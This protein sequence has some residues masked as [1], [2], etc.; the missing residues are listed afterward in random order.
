[1]IRGLMLL[2]V[3]LLIAPTVRAH[4]LAPSLLEVV[5]REDGRVKLLFKTPVVQPRGARLEPV[6]PESCRVEESGK[7]YLSGTAAVVESLL[8]CGEASLVGA[9][10]GVSGLRESGTNAIARIDLGD[11]RIAQSVLHAGQPN[12]LVSPQ[13]SWIET[14]FA[15]QRLGFTHILQGL[16]HLLF[17]A[18]LVLLSGLGR[19]LLFTITAFTL[20]HSVTL[21]LAALGWLRLPAAPIEIAIA[22]SI[23]WLALA[24]VE[25]ADDDRPM[26]RHPGWMALGFGLLHGLGFAGAL[27]ET[28]LPQGDIPLALASFNIGIELGQLLF[29]SLLIA[30][31]GLFRRFVRRW[32]RWANLAAAYAVGGLAAFWLIERIANSL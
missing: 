13:P 23:L 4:P 24:L 3:L 11:G 5:V 30:L 21:S 22:L 2:A 8:D 19:R 7:V 29:V 31:A 6:Y 15:Y 26:W 20:G 12:L 28:G 14:A 9:R 27:L 17:V 16:D 10:F 18:G 25:S 1:M 32:P